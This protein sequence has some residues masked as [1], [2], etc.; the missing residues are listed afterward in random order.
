MLRS[1]QL[2]INRMTR[3]LSRLVEGADGEQAVDADVVQQLQGLGRRQA[4]IQQATYDLATG[5][6]Q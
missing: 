3:R 1:L 2:R 5:R 4:R 6:N